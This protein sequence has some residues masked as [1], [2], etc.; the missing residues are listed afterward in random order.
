MYLLRLMYDK[1]GWLGLV[2]LIFTIVIVESYASHMGQKDYE[3]SFEKPSVGDIYIIK[4]S[5]DYYVHRLTSVSHDSLRL[6]KPNY[7]LNIFDDADASPLKSD[8]YLF[9]N[10]FVWMSRSELAGLLKQEQLKV[11][12]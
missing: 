11:Y 6:Q 8:S 10:D 9:A 2:I 3:S 5:N 7:K 12:H 4:R 1:L